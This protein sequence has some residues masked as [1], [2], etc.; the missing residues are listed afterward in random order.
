MARHAN[1]YEIAGLTP[2]YA[3]KL[4]Q[5]CDGKWWVLSEGEDYQVRQNLS[6][7]AYA[8]GRTH[9]FRVSVRDIGNGRIAFRAV[10]D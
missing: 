8:Y 5:W 4:W 7:A 3:Y 6:S 10:R 9:G 1:R 2:R